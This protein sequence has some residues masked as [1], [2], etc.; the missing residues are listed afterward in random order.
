MRITI[1]VEGKTERAFKGKLVEFLKTRIAEM[2]RIK[3]HTC[4]GLFT[5]K[6]SSS[7]L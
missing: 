2:P 6:A 1:I 3:F 7:T 5:K 4:D